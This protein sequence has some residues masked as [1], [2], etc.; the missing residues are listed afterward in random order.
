MDAFI[1]SAHLVCRMCSTFIC[2]VIIVLRPVGPLGGQYLFLILTV[3]E[4]VF[5]PSTSPSAQIEATVVNMAG[6][7]FGLGWSNLG[8]ACS[9]FAAGRY[10]VDSSAS[11]GI[12]ALFLLILGFLTGLARSSL[13]RLTFASRAAGLVSAFLLTST[14]D[15]PKWKYTSFTQ[16]L[17]VCVIAGGSSLF[18]AL[19]ARFFVPNG[20]YAKDTINALG[21][22]KDLVRLATTRNIDPLPASATAPPSP[23]PTMTDG[24]PP[25]PR[26]PVPTLESL[27]RSC[28]DAS[29]AL[30]ASYA[31]SAFELRI[32][33]VPVSQ[34]KPL[35]ATVG[36]V[37]EE[38]AWGI[39]RAGVH[40]QTEPGDPL[41]QTKTKD[42]AYRDDRLTKDEV[43]LL[44]TLDD[45]SRACADAIGD[46]ITSL[47]ASIGLCFGIKTAGFAHE[48]KVSHEEP[49]TGMSKEHA[50]PVP[51]KGQA[52]DKQMLLNAHTERDK[53]IEARASLQAQLNSVVDSM[54]DAHMLHMSPRPGLGIS[55]TSSYGAD[56]DHS[57]SSHHHQLFRKSLY[58]TSLLHISS[59][60]IRALTL[61]IAVLELHMTS[62]TRIFFLRPSW[63]WLGMSPRALVVEQ[64]NEDPNVDPGSNDE[65]SE[66][67]H[68]TNDA[69]HGTGLSAQ[70]A[71]QGLFQ[72][73]D[74]ALLISPAVQIESQAPLYKKFKKWVAALR[75]VR[76]TRQSIKR[77]L[78]NVVEFPQEV[79][80][81]TW[82][83]AG[84][85]QFRVKFSK[86]VR[87][88]Q[89]SKHARH[90][91]K[92]A[93]GVTLLGIPSFLPL[94]SAG[95]T[96]FTYTHGVWAIIS[97][98]YVLEP[99]T[100]LTWRVGMMRICG[101]CIGAVFAYVTW[102]IC[103]S[104]P[105]GLVTMVTAGEI[106]LTW[107]VRSSTPGVG[108]VASVT[109]PPIV[110]AEYLHL[111]Y[112]S[113]IDLASFRG[114]QI[115]I[116][117]VGAILVNHFLFPRHCRVMFL[118]GMAQVMASLTQLYLHLSQRTLNEKARTRK[119]M[120][121]GAKLDLRLREMIAR[122]T[123]LLKQ[124]DNEISLMP[125]P[126]RLYR[127]ST[128]TV[129]R[130]ADLMS[131]L[132][133][134]R[135]NV[136]QREAILQVL[137][138]RQHTISCICIVLF[139]CEHAFRSRRPL[140]Q[141]LPSP[142][143]AFE[144]LSRE[145]ME[146][147]QDAPRATDIAYAVAE[148]EVLE[149][150]V[151]ALDNL[152]LVTRELFG[153]DEWLE[154][155]DLGR[156]FAQRQSEAETPAFQSPRVSVRRLD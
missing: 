135:E 139:A 84:V 62:R 37:R 80:R 44:A 127:E 130:I 2:S 86:F 113:V 57:A 13:P 31:Y 141:M 34:I 109:I 27:Q 102:A 133:R 121:R 64:T 119:G 10:G 26:A 112:P 118:S 25:T 87:R 59:E 81:N 51:K 50:T 23:S 21:L 83:K 78:A 148:N 96:Y 73:R 114:F 153:T 52:R 35:L 3:K 123:L 68:R 77:G 20:G 18:V 42:M 131:G 29:L 107:L 103:R 56:L 152:I 76:I 55:P 71:R 126:T 14:P 101:T 111:T 129:Q 79:L 97:F 117:I 155:C 9:T 7:L 124:M 98:M 82:N 99:N 61:I 72:R 22:L 140:P 11:R 43:E 120:L 5:P 17:F 147:L 142:R 45:P 105:Y 138:H 106:L 91:V 115:V 65:P 66:S 94:G 19:V 53:L 15:Y 134:I 122:E 24:R 69:V 136:P 58:A 116:G 1:P 108:V 95:R 49:K 6:A 8:L 90:A 54:N 48:A 40:V 75:Q 30:H 89:H 146:S 137:Q 36:R 149:E 74:T 12:R 132:R 70:E 104:N 39:V 110:F 41:P 88:I 33:R 151:D 16:L 154:S 60:I 125:K 100:A 63:M 150:M 156:S 92:N 85:L 67:G 145:M 143:K 47:Q 128:E 93:V 46:G 144:A 38:L 4:L 28:L 32:G